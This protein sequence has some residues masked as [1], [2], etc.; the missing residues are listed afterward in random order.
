[1]LEAIT[2]G[3]GAPAFPRRRCF[4]ARAYQMI[5]AGDITRPRATASMYHMV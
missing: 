3:E 5:G 2:A 1:M 4:I